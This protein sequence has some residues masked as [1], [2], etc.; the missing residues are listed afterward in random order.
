MRNAL[1]AP[2]KTKTK[3]KV[4]LKVVAVL[5]QRTFKSVNGQDVVAIPL[6]LDALTAACRGG[7]FYCSH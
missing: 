5:G 4:Q 7:F 3:M 1:T 2:P 6:L